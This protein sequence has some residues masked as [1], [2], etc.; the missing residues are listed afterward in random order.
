MTLHVNMS[1]HVVY[2]WPSSVVTRH[3]QDGLH[4]SIVMHFLN[5]ISR[6]QSTSML[7]ATI[8]TFQ[9]GAVLDIQP[10]VSI[11]ILKISTSVNKCV[12]VR[13]EMTLICIL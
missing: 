5:S 12:I 2:C 10:E 7:M 1:I 8:R 3:H 9:I 11:Q 4:G 6:D 13:L